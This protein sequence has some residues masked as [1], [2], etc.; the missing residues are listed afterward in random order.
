MKC[1]VENWPLLAR[2]EST[3]C[4]ETVGFLGKEQ[5]LAAKG[6]HVNDLTKQCLVNHFHRMKPTVNPSHQQCLS[7]ASSQPAHGQEVCLW[8]YPF[9]L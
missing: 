6:P 3:D 7:T 8:I 1:F 9:R 2:Q 4:S 5:T